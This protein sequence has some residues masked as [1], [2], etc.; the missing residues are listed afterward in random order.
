MGAY[1]DKPVEPIRGSAI[2]V[3]E[4]IG[5]FAAAVRSTFRSAPIRSRGDSIEW[6]AEMLAALDR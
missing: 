2:E 6:F 3:A 4:Q 1:G 5:A